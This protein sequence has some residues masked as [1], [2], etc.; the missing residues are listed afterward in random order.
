MR[1]LRDRE[2][3]PGA[4]AEHRLL[5]RSLGW[6]HAIGGSLSVLWLVMPHSPHAKDSLVLV[7]TIGALAIAAILFAFGEWLSLA[8][9]QVLMLGTTTVI[10]VAAVGSGEHGSVYGLFYLW[11]TLYAFSFFSPGQAMFQ[12]ATVAGAYAVVLSVQLVPTAWYEDVGR[13]TLTIATLLASGWLVRTL[14]KQLRERDQHLRLGIEQS[15]LAS[16]TIAFDGTLLDVNDAGARLIGEPRD[17]VIG[18]NVERLRH[19]DDPAIHKAMARAGPAGQVGAPRHEVRVVRKSGHV[20]WVSLTG[21]IVR[22]DRGRPVHAFA[23]FDD[24]TER[25]LQVARQEALSRLAQLAVV[26]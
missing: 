16:A 4:G 23:Q 3:P 7:A 24:I 9:V 10:S 17:D 15:E 2:T 18:T 14:T 1:L 25:R 8:A 20:R 12:V 19:P 22:D 11:A 5:T 21:S 13:W 26:G 6:L